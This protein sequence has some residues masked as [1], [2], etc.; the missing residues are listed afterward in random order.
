[1]SI[2]TECDR[3]LHILHTYWTLQLTQQALFQSTTFTLHAGGTWNTAKAEFNQWR[4]FLKIQLIISLML[5]TAVSLHIIVW[6]TVTPCSSVDGQQLFWGLCCFHLQ[7]LQIRWF[8]VPIRMLLLRDGGTN[9]WLIPCRQVQQ[10]HFRYLCAF[11]KRQGIGTQEKQF[12]QKRLL[13]IG[14]IKL[15]S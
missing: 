14:D 9:R 8:S 10:T 2:Y 13:S 12:K 7:G 5:Y 15:R 6:Y 4:T 3:R 11:P 1:M